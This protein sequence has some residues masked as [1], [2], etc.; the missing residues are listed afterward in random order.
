MLPL[1]L[2]ALALLVYGSLYPFHFEVTARAADP[3][4]AILNGW[5]AEWDRF[6]VQDVALNI[7]LYAIPAFAAA[8]L[9]LRRRS[10][11]FTAAVVIVAA[12][13]LS[14]AMETAQV[15]DPGRD[16]S[17]LDV[18]SNTVGGAIGA[19]VAIWGQRRIREFSFR[20]LRGPCA[21]LL[22]LWAIAEFFPFIPWIGRTHLS[23]SIHY[24]VRLHDLSP[25][26]ILVALAEW[27]TVA[28]LLEIALG[29]LLTSWLAALML[30]TIVAHTT[31]QGRV[32]AAWEFAAIAL[33]LALWHFSAKDSRVAWC[34]VLLGSAILVHQ[35]QPF[36]F[37][38][39]PQPFSWIPFAATLE[40][41]REPAIAIIADKGFEYG[42][43]IFLLRR[44]GWPYWRA[45][46]VVAAALAC[47]EAIQMYLPGR[48]PEITDPLLAVI[49]TVLLVG[50]EPRKARA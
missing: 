24:L 44:A 26:K 42:G 14:C 41:S 35:L 49:M 34:A 19:A 25:V 23:Y 5:P 27:F 45:A 13:A 8:S 47:T 3:L 4:R 40:S 6:M 12:C 18:L 32:W 39:V 37:L 48:T 38:S 15:W 46:I 16:P 29:R 21:I 22:G 31:I 11:A 33:A 7:I 9:L 20:G 30:L 36:Y 28:T 17:A 2:L 10:R 50:A 1:L 43:L